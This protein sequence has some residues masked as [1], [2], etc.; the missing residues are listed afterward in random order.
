MTFA[1]PAL[2]R[3][4]NAEPASMLAMH[5]SSSVD[6]LFGLSLPLYNSEN[7]MFQRHPQSLHL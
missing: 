4:Q 2:K 6:S 7:A 3:T 1:R 5:F